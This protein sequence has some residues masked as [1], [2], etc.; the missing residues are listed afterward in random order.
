MNEFSVALN[1]LA[2]ER[3][4]EMYGWVVLPNHYHFLAKTG[5]VKEA[6]QQL[7]RL[8]GRTSFKWNRADDTRGRQVWFNAAETAMKSERHF[9]ASLLYVFH[10]PVKHGY[11][12]RWQDW[13]FSNAMDWLQSVGRDQAVQ[14]WKEFPIE[15]YGSDWDP[16]DL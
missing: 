7:G 4:W 16:P 9:W 13:P 1:N 8:H 2:D 12:A 15:D 5:S 11:A 10:N 6:I 3:E 14:T